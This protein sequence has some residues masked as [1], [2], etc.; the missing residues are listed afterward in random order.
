MA[1]GKGYVRCSWL[2]KRHGNL[3]PA[4]R[5]RPLSGVAGRARRA[6]WAGSSCGCRV[7][8][9]YAYGR[10]SA[11]CTG[12][13]RH[14]REVNPEEC[15]TQVSLDVK[16]L[17]FLAEDD[18][19]A[20]TT[21]TAETSEWL[22]RHGSSGVAVLRSRSHCGRHPRLVQL[23][24]RLQVVHDLVADVR[25]DL[26]HGQRCIE[27]DAVDHRAGRRDVGAGCRRASGRQGTSR[28]YVSIPSIP[29]IMASASS[30]NSNAL[31]DLPAPHATTATTMRAPNKR[32]RLPNLMADECSSRGINSSRPNSSPGHLSETTPTHSPH[33]VAP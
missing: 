25:P 29:S 7:S 14:A 11:D 20:E 30:S 26:G 12:R 10:R 2:Y 13:C 4:P 1:A 17:M 33:P 32:E 18:G 8:S 9:K 15:R 22:P 16:V 23:R 19:D 27:R 6:R 24:R 5:T 21:S 28:R 31:A 3:A